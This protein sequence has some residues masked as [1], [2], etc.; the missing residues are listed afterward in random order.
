M[1]TLTS[2]ELNSWVASIIWP[3]TRILGVI[4]VAPL[5][6]NVSVPARVKISLGILLSLIIAPTVPAVPAVDPMSATGLLILAQQLVIGLTMGFAVRVV[7][8]GIEL[9]GE[10]SGMTMGL[11]F[12]SFFDPQTKARTSAISQ[13]LAL[14]MV[15]IYMA[16]DLHLL[17]L[18][19][20][21]KSFELMPISSGLISNQGLFQIVGLGGRIFSAGV[22]L[23]MPIV[24][25]LLITNVALGILTRAAP[26]LNIFGIGFPVTIG[27]GL[28]MIGVVL[29][30]LT[31]PII[32]LL[33]EG[34]DAMG[35]IAVAYA[36]L[37][38]AP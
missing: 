1:I 32:H 8:A 2:A 25:A 16:S 12:A 33:Q 23:S 27:V 22:Q 19:T 36:P 38:N 14:I 15:M 3:L 10:I 21:A 26:Q 7:F 34:I 9:A 20:L 29:P 11:G 5:F 17:V 18:T 4:S 35:K 31:M 37:G 24:A 30:Y 28:I 6:G 13:F